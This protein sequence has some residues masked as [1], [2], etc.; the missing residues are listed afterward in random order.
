M[1]KISRSPGLRPGAY[2][3]PP[4]PLAGFRGRAPGKG[5]GEG[6]GNGWSD[7]RGG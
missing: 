5:M 2:S 4:V 6:V 3:A 7:G 1:H